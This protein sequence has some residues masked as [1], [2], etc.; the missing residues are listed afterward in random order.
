MEKQQLALFGLGQ[1]NNNNNNNKK[2][3]NIKIHT[4]EQQTR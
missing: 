3:Q 1:A 2:L 4:P